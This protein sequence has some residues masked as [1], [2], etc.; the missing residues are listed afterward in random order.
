MAVSAMHPFGT[1]SWA[2]VCSSGQP[3][4]ADQA[5]H[6][7]QL[8][9]NRHWRQKVASPRADTP[10][11]AYLVDQPPSTIISACLVI[12]RLWHASRDV[13]RLVE[14]CLLF[15][16]AMRGFQPLL[17]PLHGG[18]SPAGLHENTGVGQGWLGKVFPGCVGD[19]ARMQDGARGMGATKMGERWGR[20]STHRP[21]GAAQ[22]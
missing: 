17:Q 10:A 3:G 4:C 2:K 19:L 22:R 1:R 11:G 8:A 12:A 5:L 6:A 16:A 13:R 20:V 14:G 15:N 7:G 21:A 9:Y 18:L